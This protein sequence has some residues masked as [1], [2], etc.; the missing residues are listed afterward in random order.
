M[1]KLL[2]TIT[3]ILTLLVSQMMA[4]NSL[5]IP[6]YAGKNGI[7][8]AFHASMLAQ[9]CSGLNSALHQ[10]LPDKPEI[11]VLVKQKAYAHAKDFMITSALLLNLKGQLS[12]DEILKEISENIPIFAQEYKKK[13][14]NQQ[15]ATGNIMDGIIQE[16]INFCNSIHRPMEQ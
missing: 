7:N 12:E 5:S 15:R 11:L 3:L 13:F 16:E 2:A 10:F 14:K 1:T 4:Q 6:E 9:K 8:D